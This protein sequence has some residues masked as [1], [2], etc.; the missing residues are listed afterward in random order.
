MNLRLQLIRFYFKTTSF[1]TPRLSAFQ[2]FKLFQKVRKKRVRKREE[3][4]YELAKHFKIPSEKEDIHCYEL[5]NVRGNVVFLVHG[6][7]SNAG[8]MSRFAFDLASKGYRVI[9]FDLPGH[10][11]AKSNYSNLFVCKEAFRNVLK[12]IDPKEPFTVVS[13]SFGSAVSTYTLSELEYEVD[14]FIFLTSPNSLFEV[15]NDFK[16]FI[17]LTEKSFTHVIGRATSLLNE[18]VRQVNVDEKLSQISYSKLLLLHDKF[19]KVIHVKNS[20]KI[21]A[22]NTEKAEL[23]I[24]NKIGHYRMLWNDNVLE[25]TLSFI[26]N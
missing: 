3:K 21:K 7:E 5:G 23:K 4:F 20:E 15:F 14:K 17:G 8:S 11:K 12:F 6:W 18:D 16:K 1:L 22:R 26:G 9:S 2:A 19:D 10:A 13:H 24:Y 25:D